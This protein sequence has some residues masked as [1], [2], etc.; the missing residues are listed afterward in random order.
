MVEICNDKKNKLKVI[1]DCDPGVDDMEA[2]FLAL[3]DKNCNV[4]AITTVAGN[5]STQLVYQNT[6]NILEFCGRDNI[7][8]FRGSNIN[9]SSKYANSDGYFGPDS[10]GNINLKNTELYKKEK[11]TSAQALLHYANKNIGDIHL[12]AIGPL[13]NLAIAYLLDKEFP[14]KLA[15][16]TIMGGDRSE[17]TLFN[18][19]P[20]AEFNCYSDPC[21]WKL[22]MQ[23]FKLS[24]AKKIKLIDFKFCQQNLLSKQYMIERNGESDESL[25]FCP[26]GI[27][28][29]KVF[30]FMFSK[31][32]DDGVLTCDPFA[33]FVSFYPE[34]ITSSRC[35]N[36]IKV[37]VDGEKIGHIEL[38]EQK[39]G[40]ILLIDQINIEE[41]K[42]LYFQ[43]LR[44]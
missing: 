27:L 3:S 8:V 7:P 41:F 19:T 13:T 17:N 20:W 39:N 31:A 14:K 32:S 36:V 22:V 11:Y 38:E 33:V 26:R 25:G 1:I 40:N 28:A 21:A 6:Q 15:S 42:K 43:S 44:P 12:I 2:I 4:V 10:L 9:M 37:E 18:V 23:N 29:R 34:F 24:N 30:D 35:C 5:G 16:L